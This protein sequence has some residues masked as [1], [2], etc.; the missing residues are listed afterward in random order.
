MQMM[1]PKEGLSKA[2]LEVPSR[3]K[4]RGGAEAR[5]KEI[6]EAYEVLSDSQKRATYDQFGKDGLRGQGMGGGLLLQSGY[7]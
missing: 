5:F 4:S 7:F 1:G 6:S 2:C 3:S